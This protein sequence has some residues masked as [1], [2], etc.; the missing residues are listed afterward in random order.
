MARSVLYNV[1]PKRNPKNIELDPQFYATAKSR[2]D[3]DLDMMS[4]RIE[5][6]CTLT[7]ADIYAALVGLEGAII[8]ALQNGEIVRMGQL[9]AFRITLSSKGSAT[10]DKFDTSLIN[11]GRVTFHAGKGLKTM[12]A[13][14]QYSKTAEAKPVVP[15]TPPQDPP[16]E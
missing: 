10:K 14:L 3:I 4:E 2:G 6:E 7:K 13:T 15:E 5:K 9:G 12:L 1:V 11:G 8:A 16:L